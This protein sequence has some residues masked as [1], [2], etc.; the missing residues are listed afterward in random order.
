MDWIPWF[1]AC[2]GL[3][4]ANDHMREDDASDI[5]LNAFEFRNYRTN[6][7]SG[8]QKMIERVVNQSV[9]TLV[10][11][12]MITV[13]SMSEKVFLD[14]DLLTIEIGDSGHSFYRLKEM[15]RMEFTKNEMS[16]SGW[17]LRVTFEMEGRPEEVLEFAFDQERQRLNFALTL[18]ILRTRDPDLDTS[19]PI[20]IE[21]N[22]ENDDY[23]N[24]KNAFGRVVAVPRYSPE[25][26]IPIIFS[27]SDLKLYTKLQSTSRWVYIEFF[28]HYPHQDKFLYA[29][30]P[31]THIPPQILIADDQGVRR[32]KE[33]RAEEEEAEK[34][35]LENEKKREALGGDVP[36]ASMKFDL[37][38]V[39]MKIPKTPHQIFGRLMAK[40]DYFPTVVGTFSFD[41]HKSWLQ[42]RRAEAQEEQK[43]SKHEADKL[44]AKDG[45]RREP[46]KI[47]IPM[48][49]VVKMETTAAGPAA[50]G[51][52]SNSAAAAA[53]LA[54]ARAAKKGKE[55]KEEFVKIGKLT[56]RILGYI[57][58]DLVGNHEGQRQSTKRH[59]GSDEDVGGRA[60]GAAKAGAAGEEEE[61]D[62]EEEGEES[63]EDDEEEDA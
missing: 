31:T 27:I 46:E 52:G 26:G 6:L 4:M 2:R 50:E 12:R 44:Q 19:V 40:D 22:E 23:D 54:A 56:I 15:S 63:E 34:L 14:K 24:V 13:N 43:A 60:G 47:E 42:D 10:K 57:T 8:Q 11:G 49:S 5:Q 20:E 3:T 7:E 38:N 45:H 9:T 39:K 33:K 35:R 62:E 36:I 32:K 28:V 29:K 17:L 37:K 16:G 61:S 59:Q 21:R 18:R 25:A 53:G 48:Y 55:P 41:V 1:G 51:G 58:D 30:S